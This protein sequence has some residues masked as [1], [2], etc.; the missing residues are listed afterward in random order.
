MNPKSAHQSY[1]KLFSASPQVSFVQWILIYALSATLLVIVLFLVITQVISLYSPAKYDSSSVV[2]PNHPTPI[3]NQTVDTSTWKTY[4]NAKYYYAIKY[5]PEWEVSE[6]GVEFYQYSDVV[7]LR[8][9][10]SPSEDDEYIFISASNNPENLSI[11]D[12]LVKKRF[13]SADL[14]EFTIIKLDNIEGLKYDVPVELSQQN[15]AFNKGGYF[16]QV[17]RIGEPKT[18]MNQILSTFKF[19]D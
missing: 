3:Q 1:R 6:E 16:Y 19:T 15:F 2:S 18:T 4:T 11:K 7:S 13:I 12:F 17:G 9:L 14:F 5:P 10:S 8:I